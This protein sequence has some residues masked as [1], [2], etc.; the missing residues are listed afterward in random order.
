VLANVLASDTQGWVPKQFLRRTD[1]AENIAG[2]R[3]GAASQLGGDGAQEAVALLAGERCASSHH[4]RKLFVAETD[5]RH[6]KDLARDLNM[7]AGAR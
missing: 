1:G 4:V 6:G 2:A 3:L 7:N 5:G